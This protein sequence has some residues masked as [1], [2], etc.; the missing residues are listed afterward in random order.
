MALFDEMSRPIVHNVS[1]VDLI[2]LFIGLSWAGESVAPWLERFSHM[3][4]KL[5]AA[6]RFARE[7]RKDWKEHIDRVLNIM[8]GVPLF[9]STRGSTGD[10]IKPDSG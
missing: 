10:G 8:E 4:P 9:E 7:R 2:H 3:R 5:R 6:L 1:L